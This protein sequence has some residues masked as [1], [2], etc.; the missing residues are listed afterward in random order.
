MG[1]SL[2][3]WVDPTEPLPNLSDVGMRPQSIEKHRG[4]GKGAHTGVGLQ[5]QGL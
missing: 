2:L 4:D 3:K 5:G 1:Y